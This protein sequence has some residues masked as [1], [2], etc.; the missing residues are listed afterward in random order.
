M[1][2]KIRDKHHDSFSKK[3]G[4]KQA[5]FQVDPLASSSLVKI[6]V[7]RINVLDQYHSLRSL[8]AML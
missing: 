3:L 7:D 1:P 4:W 6:S 5:A 2:G 8:L